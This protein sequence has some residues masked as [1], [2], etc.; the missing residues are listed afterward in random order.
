MYLDVMTFQLEE[1]RS[2]RNVQEDEAQR[3]GYVHEYIYTVS[4]GQEEETKMRRCAMTS[5][6]SPERQ[7]SLICHVRIMGSCH[8]T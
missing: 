6:L 4:Y 1:V 5:N 8:W 3:E 2:S 7:E